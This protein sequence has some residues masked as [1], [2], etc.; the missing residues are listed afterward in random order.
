MYKMR[1]TCLGFRMVIGLQFWGA[2]F[3]SHTSYL[4]ILLFFLVTGL[5]LIS[6]FT[7][8][9]IFATSVICDPGLQS[10]QGI[11][12]VTE[13]SGAVNVK[14]TRLGL[15]SHFSHITSSHASSPAHC[16]KMEK[17]SWDRGDGRNSTFLCECVKVSNFEKKL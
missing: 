5:Q 9:I 6:C 16:Y 12:S 15:N 17:L 14:F 4:I 11:C 13:H 2:S 7:S 1:L 10:V 3:S 8:Q